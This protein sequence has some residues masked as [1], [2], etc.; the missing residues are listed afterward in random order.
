MARAP[1]ALPTTKTAAPLV[2]LGGSATALPGRACSGKR[3]LRR[4]ERAGVRPT[5]DCGPLGYQLVQLPRGKRPVWQ[6]GVDARPFRGQRLAQLHAQASCWRNA[7]PI[8]P[9]S[10]ISPRATLA[11]NHA[12]EKEG[13][14]TQLDENHLLTRTVMMGLAVA[15][16]RCLPEPELLARHLDGV[17]RELPPQLANAQAVARQLAVLVRAVRDSTSS[18]TAPIPS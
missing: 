11:P 2:R 13:T 5:H 12:P 6:R 4:S 10:I 7:R 8:S 1:A 15:V 9:A 16:S 14:V 17:A 18:G 3:P